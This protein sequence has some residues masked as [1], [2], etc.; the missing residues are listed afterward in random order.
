MR[1]LSM[2]KCLPR[3]PPRVD[4]RGELTG[5]YVDSAV[6]RRV[7]TVKMDGHSTRVQDAYSKGQGPPPTVV[8]TAS[9]VSTAVARGRVTVRS[10]AEEEYLGELLVD[11][12]DRRYVLGD[13]EEARV[14]ARR[15]VR[16]QHR[17][18][19]FIIG[20][21]KDADKG[22]RMLGHVNFASPRY[23][24]PATSTAKHHIPSSTTHAPPTVS[25]NDLHQQALKQVKGKWEPVAPLDD[26]GVT[27]TDRRHDH[28]TLLPSATTS[29]PRVRPTSATHYTS[30]P[31]ETRIPNAANFARSSPRRG[32]FTVQAPVNYLS[33]IHI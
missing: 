2:T 19:P 3:P 21:Y 17:Y 7:P 20:E 4:P 5:R 15:A 33:L 27:S 25:F 30:P 32:V 23:A 13:K 18:R 24:P 31:H 28:P 10:A 22:P 14:R 11:D 12:A 16:Q 26:Y 9:V 6:S 29:N 8:Q 1:G